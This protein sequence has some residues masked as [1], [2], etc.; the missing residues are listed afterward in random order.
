[1]CCWLVVHCIMFMKI[2]TLV[3]EQWLQRALKGIQVVVSMHLVIYP[4]VVLY[5]SVLLVSPDL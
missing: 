4:G 5:H 2:I 1:M 3:I